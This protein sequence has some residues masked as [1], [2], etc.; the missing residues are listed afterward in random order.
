MPYELTQRDRDR[1]RGVHPDLARVVLRAFASSDMPFTVLEGLRTVARQK[2]LVA[3][4]ASKTM[5]SRHI[6]AQ[7]GYGHAVDL[8]PVDDKGRPLWDWP[9]YH[10]LAKVIK[11]A[12][13]EEGVPI[14]WGG[15]WKRFKDGP[16]WQL[17]WKQYPGAAIEVA[18]AEPYTDRTEG[19]L[20]RS[21]TV[22]GAATAGGG[23]V[24]LMSQASG[25]LSEAADHLSAASIFGL[26]AAGL[27]LIGLA[28]V[29]YA[30]WDDAGRPLPWKRDDD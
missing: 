28:V 22:G 5:N 17:P 10:Q 29:L 20:M 2:Q 26:V 1:L 11:R 18:D 12:A 30:R 8:A 13:R 16:H 19:D 3:K 23:A 21:R 7:N 4:G 9:L 24:A 25:S 15:D 14:E 6:K 27:V